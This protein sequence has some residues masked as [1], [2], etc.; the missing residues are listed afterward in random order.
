MLGAEEREGIA[1]KKMRGDRVETINVLKACA[2][3]V[4]SHRGRSVGERRALREAFGDAEDGGA[5]D[6]DGAEWR[7]PPTFT[8]EKVLPH[9]V[10][11]T[12]AYRRETSSQHLCVLPS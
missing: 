12:G 3:Q 2:A 6:C 10:P 11:S 4:D 9:G 7:P 5:S 1:R 8:A